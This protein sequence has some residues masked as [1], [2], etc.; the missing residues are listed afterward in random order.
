MFCSGEQNNLRASQLK[1]T[2][3]DLLTALGSHWPY[4]HLS[5]SMS[6]TVERQLNDPW[7]HPC[8]VTS[9]KSA[10]RR[11]ETASGSVQGTH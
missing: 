7:P 4:F 3:F 9:L 10:C 6:T 11:V 1:L 2:N 8:D 5:N